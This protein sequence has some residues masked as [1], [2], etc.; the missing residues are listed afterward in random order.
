[1]EILD[2]WPEDVPLPRLSGCINMKRFAPVLFVLTCT[3]A[4]RGEPVTSSLTASLDTGSLVGT[5]FSVSFSY[6]SSQVQPVGDSYVQLDSF[7]FT[8]LA[9]PF[10]RHDIFQGGQVIFHDAASNNRTASFQVILPPS[11]PVSNITFGLSGLGVIGYIR[12]EWPIR[13]RLV[14]LW[15]MIVHQGTIVSIRT[16]ESSGALGGQPGIEIQVFSKPSSRY[17]MNFLRCV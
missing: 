6:D 17:A 2:H 5:R 3:A 14:Q 16:V 12:S 7:E 8:L 10:T 13:G 4:A 1:M 15:D 9:V 11:S